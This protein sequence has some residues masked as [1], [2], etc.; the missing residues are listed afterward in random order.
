MLCKQKKGHERKRRVFYFNDI[1]K[2]NQKILINFTRLLEN[3]RIM[4]NRKQVENDSRVG[5]SS[6]FA[7]VSFLSSPG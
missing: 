3:H 5:I 6:V 2:T 1:V 4:I 7:F